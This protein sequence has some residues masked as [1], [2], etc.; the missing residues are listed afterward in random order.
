MLNDTSLVLRREIRDDGIVK[1]SHGNQMMSWLVVSKRLQANVIR[2]GVETTEIAVAFTLKES[3]RGEYRPFLS[4][5]PAFAYLPLRNY[6][7]KFIVQ[8]DFI[9]PSSREE[10]D[11]D[12]AWNQWLLSEFPALFVNAEQ[13]FCSLSCYQENPGKAVTAYLCFVPL[14]GE[15]HG[16]FS[17]LPH[18]IIS[19]L[20][21]SNCLFLDG[22]SNDWVLPCRTLRG[23]N[24]QARLTL[25]DSLLQK[26]LG[27]V[28]LNKDIIISDALAKALG[29]HD[30]GPKLLIDFIS[31]LC[32]SSDGIKS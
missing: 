13:S 31:S 4:Q 24:E 21:M 29:V 30:Y 2:Q 7:L 15:V 18:M 5:Q 6:G 14:V 10:V 1:V 20:R 8:G 3:E 25:P 11:G 19:K 32:H 17:H 22:P 27:L 16:F 9:L 23:W 12:S 26:H 28:Y